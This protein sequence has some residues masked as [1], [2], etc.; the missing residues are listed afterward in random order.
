MAD[1]A[2][3]HATLASTTQSLLVSGR[4]SGVGFVAGATP[5]QDPGRF[6]VQQGRPLTGRS[7]LGVSLVSV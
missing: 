2:A 3:N 7:E 5:M 1:F 4:T 6:F